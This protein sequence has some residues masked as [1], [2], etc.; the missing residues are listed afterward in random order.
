[1]PDESGHLGPNQVSFLCDSIIFPAIAIHPKLQPKMSTVQ[2]HQTQAI[3]AIWL[4]LVL[5]DGIKDLRRI[6]FFVPAIEV[7]GTVITEFHW[8]TVL[9]GTG[10]CNARCWSLFGVSR[11]QSHQGTIELAVI[12]RWQPVPNTV[13]IFGF[14]YRGKAVP[15]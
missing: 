13:A 8:R 11:Y 7:T 9:Y 15:Y 1:M 14:Q 2:S 5:K 12:Y 6:L 4:S 10:D 3:F